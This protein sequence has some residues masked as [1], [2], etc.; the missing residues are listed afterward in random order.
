[1][2][3]SEE[4]QLLLRNIT[5]GLWKTN[6]VDKEPVIEFASGTFLL[7]WLQMDQIMIVILMVIAQVVTKAE[8]P[9]KS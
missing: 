6:S 7:P 8:F 5:G 2:S 9:Q 4:Q 3:L 1:M